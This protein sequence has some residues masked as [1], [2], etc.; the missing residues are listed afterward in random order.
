MNGS[1]VK[2]NGYIKYK[3]VDTSTLAGLKAA[4]KLKNNDWIIGS[5]GFSTI[6]FYKYLRDDLR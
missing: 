6:Q 5:V 3:T 2:Y 4:E 1:K